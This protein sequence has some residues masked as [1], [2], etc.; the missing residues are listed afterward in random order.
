[1]TLAFRHLA[2]GAT[3]LAVLAAGCGFI[4]N[5]NGPDGVAIKKFAV[6]PSEVTAG[7]AAMLRWE[8]EGA[9]SIQVDNGIGVVKA[10]GSVEVKAATTTSYTITARAGTSTATATVQLHV[11]PGTTAGS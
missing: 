8:V 6:T 3:L 9:E 2:P 5:I 7:G 11:G 1:M 10:K 4:E